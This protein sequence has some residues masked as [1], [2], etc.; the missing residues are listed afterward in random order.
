[1]SRFD[2]LIDRVQQAD[3]AAE[4]FQHIY[5]EDFFTTEDFA[6][7]VSAPEVDLTPAVSD[8]DLFEKLFG[9]G[10]K[11]INFPG[12]IAD[13]EK[14]LDWR[15]EGRRARTG[16][17]GR[18]EGFGVTLRLMEPRTEILSELRDFI[19][20]E[21]FNRA[22]ASRFGIDYEA[23]AADNGIQ[24]YL[25]GYEISPHA[26]VRRKAATFMVNINSGEN[27]K[28]RNHHTH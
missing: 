12:S 9:A 17:N 28:A 6:E 22:I 15:K 20:S 8:E 19:G 13:R 25:D 5:I 21:A 10:Y 7:I 16:E 27:S 2:Y 23:V 18:S 24:K 26:D 3:M 4:P 11:I 14:Y 1:M